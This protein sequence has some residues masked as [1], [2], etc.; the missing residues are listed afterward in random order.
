MKHDVEMGSVA[1]IHRSSSMT[2]GSGN[3][4][5]YCGRQIRRHIQDGYGISSLQKSKLRME[6][7]EGIPKTAKRITL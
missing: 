3:S 2:S 4:N 1:R 5:T 6:C 7:M